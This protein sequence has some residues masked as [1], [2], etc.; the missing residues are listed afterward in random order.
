MHTADT[1]ND[2]V[3]LRFSVMTVVWGI[4]GMLVSPFIAASM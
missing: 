4:V 3:V 1:C 2:K